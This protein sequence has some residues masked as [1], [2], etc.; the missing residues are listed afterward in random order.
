MN[1]EN[2]ASDGSTQDPGRDC[3][4]AIALG[5]RFLTRSKVDPTE[6]QVVRAE[7][8][9]GH[10]VYSGPWV[11]RLTYKLRRLIPRSVE[12][13][14]GAGGELLVEVDLATGDARLLGHGE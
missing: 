12:E 14:I 8:L 1:D 10:P 6:Y 11:W 9:V 2:R 4:E 13:E 7:N 5:S 3:Q